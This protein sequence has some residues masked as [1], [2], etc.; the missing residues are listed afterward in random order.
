MKYLTLIT[1]LFTSLLFAA[2]PAPKTDPGGPPP[3]MV[4]A[5]EEAAKNGIPFELIRLPSSNETA[6]AAGPSSTASGDGLKNS[7]A[8][9][10][11]EVGLS[12]G[13]RSKGGTT[14]GSQEANAFQ[15][16]DPSGSN[17]S[18]WLFILLGIGLIIGRAWLPIIPI[19]A[20]CISIG[21][22]LVLL[23]MPTFLNEHPWVAVILVGLA[24]LIALLFVGGKARWFDIE[25]APERQ[26]ELEQKGHT[27]AAGALAHLR[28][29]APFASA[30]NVAQASNVLRRAKEAAK[31]TSTP[32]P[33]YAAP[34]YA[35]P[36]YV[37]PA[38]A[39]TPPPAPAV[40]P[41]PAP[42]TV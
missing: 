17:I 6:N 8:G 11:P 33:V 41:A 16:F 34:Q 29:N 24:A 13:S 20:G 12:G 25:T 10:A 31:R 39:P 4:R 28:A 36:V 23:V 30:K 5:A 14:K 9:S 37:Q 7:V 26:Q 40:V 19:S 32:A 42:G 38:P 18:G 2:A 15:P 27:L 1:L 3:E 22:G 35:P 21:V